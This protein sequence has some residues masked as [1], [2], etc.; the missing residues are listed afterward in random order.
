MAKT[1]FELPAEVYSIDQVLFCAEELERLAADLA[2]QRRASSKTKA[3]ELI[4]SPE[5]E[6]LLKLLP[7]AHQ[8]DE[9][10][11]ET[12]RSQLETVAA[13]WPA[14]HLVMAVPASRKLKHELVTWVR[15]EISPQ[16]LVEFSADPEIAGGIV[17]RTKSHIIDCSFRSGLLKDPGRFTG[18]LEHV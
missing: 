16:I 10:A 2:R 8:N 17:I 15:S 9:A 5:T 6:S 7:A 13:Q 18:L 14:I 1:S 12:L 11:L 4:I 3:G